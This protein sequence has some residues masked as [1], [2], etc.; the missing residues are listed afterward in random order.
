MKKLIG[1]I[2]VLLLFASCGGNESLDIAFVKVAEEDQK[3]FKEEI[4]TN[5]KLYLTSS[6]AEKYKISQNT[7]ITVVTA[8]ESE[9]GSANINWDCNMISAIYSSQLGIE[10]KELIKT[11]EFEVVSDSGRGLALD[12][13][14]DKVM[15]YLYFPSSQRTLATL[16]MQ[17]SAV[18][19][20]IKENETKSFLA[21]K[22]ETDKLVTACIWAV[23]QGEV[24][25]AL[26]AFNC[27]LSNGKEFRVFFLVE[28][29]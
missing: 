5:A 29:K 23:V 6:L 3:L 15:S 19:Q 13:G 4:G 28:K 26:V 16:P 9:D 25:Q 12:L 14:E 27:K 2:A 8:P 17:F 22:T 21:G 24:P 7:P 11:S 18:K 20:F 10:L 1:V